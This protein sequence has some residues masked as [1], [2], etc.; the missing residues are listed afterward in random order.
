MEERKRERLVLRRR[1]TIFV[2]ADNSSVKVEAFGQ[3]RPVTQPD[4]VSSAELA[5]NR[6][7]LHLE[8]AVVV[9]SPLDTCAADH[10][11]FAEQPTML[12]PLAANPVKLAALVGFFGREQPVLMPGSVD[13]MPATISQGKFLAKQSGSIKV[14]L[15]G[16][17]HHTVFCIRPTSPP[18]GLVVH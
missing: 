5:A 2:G 14:S 9:P 4:S 8:L 12:I 10:L 7:D 17:A 6:G 15:N 3:Q 1:F 18:S 16:G 13:T 11:I